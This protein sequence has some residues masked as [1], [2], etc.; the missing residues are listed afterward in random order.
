MDICLRFRF[1][2]PSGQHISAMSRISDSI[3]PVVLLCSLD[4][5]KFEQSSRAHATLLP[6]PEKEDFRKV[7]IAWMKIV[8]KMLLM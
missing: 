3:S 5:V 6:T 8:K 4:R 2:N 7:L 1:S